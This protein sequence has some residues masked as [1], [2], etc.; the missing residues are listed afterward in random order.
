MTLETQLNHSLRAAHLAAGARYAPSLMVAIETVAAILKKY[1]AAENDGNVPT[2]CEFC[3]DEGFVDNPERTRTP[4]D[5]PM[6][7]GVP[8]P[9]CAK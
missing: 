9:E 5:D 7:V 8:C 2:A 3:A 6:S 1:E 4:F